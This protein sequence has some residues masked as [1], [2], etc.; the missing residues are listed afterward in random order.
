MKNN[1]PKIWK[2][3]IRFGEVIDLVEFS[4]G[5]FCCPVCGY[6]G[7]DLMY[8]IPERGG[9]AW[10]FTICPCCSVEYGYEDSVSLRMI[11]NGIGQKERWRELRE[12]WLKGVKITEE[13]R[14][15]LGHIGI[16]VAQDDMNLK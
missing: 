14:K 8:P 5:V 13:L 9:E 2:T 3:K 16:N 7:V 11:E 4:E 10:D 1:F 12:E 15:Q 6:P